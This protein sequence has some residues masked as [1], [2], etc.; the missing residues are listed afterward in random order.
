MQ[1]F[2]KPRPDPNV[3]R[4]KGEL[5]NAMLAMAL[6]EAGEA[7]TDTRKELHARWL[8][9]TF[10]AAAHGLNI[11]GITEGYGLLEWQP[12]RDGMRLIWH[13]PTG[14]ICP[15]ARLYPQANGTWAAMV[16]AGVK[17]SPEEAMAAAEWAVS[18]LAS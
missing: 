8:W 1:D 9:G 11:L 3:E 6:A 5:D 16:V 10:Q 15:L 7:E 2:R 4:I 14:L 18:R 12:D 17:D 13:S